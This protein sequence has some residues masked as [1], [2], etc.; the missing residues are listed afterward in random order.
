MSLFFA[1]YGYDGA[2]IAIFES[3]FA[4][5]R[6]VSYEDEFTL[7]FGDAYTQLDER[8][9]ILSY[10]EVVEILG[11]KYMLLEELNHRIQDAFND[12]MYW[13]AVKV[14]FYPVD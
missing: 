10:Q 7:E 2:E 9:R 14:N 5:D 6:W 13:I 4:R 12:Q 3:A 1:S 8:R 11:G